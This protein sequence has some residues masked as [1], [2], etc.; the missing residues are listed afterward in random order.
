MA[1]QS[2]LHLLLSHYIPSLSLLSSIA[3]DKEKLSRC[4]I[5]IIKEASL[6]WSVSG[7]IFLLFCVLSMTINT[8]IY[9][10]TKA[11][12]LSS[13]PRQEITVGVRDG[14]QV[15]TNTQT[16]ADYKD[17]LDNSSDIQKVTYFSDGKTLN[18]TLWLGDTIP[19]NPSRD[20]ANNLVYG[21]LIDVDNN[22][23]TGKFGVDYQKEIQWSNTTEQWNNFIAEYSSPN[24]LRILESQRNRSILFE[25]NQK[26][27]PI[28]LDLES[29]TSP[30]KYRILCYTVIIYGNNSKSVV[31]LTNWIDVPP[32]TYTFSTLPNP[33]V[34]RQGEQ[35]DIGVQLKSSSGVPP[36][37]VRFFPSEN[38][39]SIKI[40][41]NP[42]RSSN[43][44][45]FGLSPAPF[46]IQV[47][48]DAQVGYYSIPVMVNIS[49]GSLFPSE[50]I[51]LPN[52]NLSVP[53]RGY[54]ST[55]A[56]LSMSVVRPPTISEQVKEF[57]GTYGALISLLGA[58][59]AGGISTYV[60][61]YLKNRKK[62]GAPIETE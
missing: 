14:L 50:F 57:W 43:S 10:D 4:R 26:Y 60:F 36:Q 56:N 2:F 6:R 23:T 1:V 31:D 37:S 21:I 38:Y 45:S 8:Y 11:Q 29:I 28:S 51:E 3:R 18:V 53:T 62:K 59:F 44:T 35:M 15:V 39:S 32:A 42:D 13:F 12:P 16:K 17:K 55:Q 25:E 61:D 5:D 41:F 27:V 33:L 58:G 20:G 9:N 49:S 46:R 19:E 30:T 54:I 7:L 47:P 24:H 48:Q 22:P 34:M 40:V 52:F